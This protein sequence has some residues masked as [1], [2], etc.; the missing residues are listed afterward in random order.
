MFSFY[1][2]VIHVDEFVYSLVVFVLYYDLFVACDVFQYEIIFRQ[3]SYILSVFNVSDIFLMF[4]VYINVYCFFFINP[5]L[6]C[7]IKMLY[8]IVNYNNSNTCSIFSIWVKIKFQQFLF[9]CYSQPNSF[10]YIC[11]KSSTVLN[12]IY[13]L[14]ILCNIWNNLCKQIPTSKQQKSSCRHIFK[15]LH[16][17]NTGY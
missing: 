5:F 2:F 16:F 10:R 7:N 9:F 3:K 6:S 11:T 13:I 8:G 1:V 15:K 4:L 17:R 14:C 12:K